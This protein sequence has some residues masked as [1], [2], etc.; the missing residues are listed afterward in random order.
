M[1]VVAS[2]CFYCVKNQVKSGRKDR[3][4]EDTTFSPP[5]P[6]SRPRSIAMQ[7]SSLYDMIPAQTFHKIVFTIQSVN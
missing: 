6:A 4:G 2:V 5:G 1:T 3:R 7:A